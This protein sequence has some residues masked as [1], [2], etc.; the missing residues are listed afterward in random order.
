MFSDFITPYLYFK[1]EL[2]NFVVPSGSHDQWTIL[3]LTSGSFEV[4]MKKRTDIISKNDMYIF[5]AH[6]QFKRQIIDKISYYGIQFDINPSS[7]D[8]FTIPHGK[9][10]NIDKKRIN[11]NLNL[12]DYYLNQNDTLSNNIKLHILFDIL[13]QV[14]LNPVSVENMKIN[15][16]AMNYILKYIEENYTSKIFLEEI[17]N[18]LC[19]TTSGIIYKFKKY[20]GM[21]PLN[22]IIQLKTNLAKNLLLQTNM[23]INEIAEQCGYENMYYFSN[24]FKKITGLPPSSFRNKN[25]L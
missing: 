14:S 11:R 3:I 18:K 1:N 16:P 15:D 13:Y 25:R 24:A 7:S 21:T 4:Q 5:P 10:A 23:S 8:A 2:D 12:L 20:T 6:M 17:A 9:P 19:M 22:Y